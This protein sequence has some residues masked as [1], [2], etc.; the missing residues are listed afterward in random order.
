[1]RQEMNARGLSASASSLTGIRRVISALQSQDVAYRVLEPQSRDADAIADWIE[2]RFP[3]VGMQIDWAR[4]PSSRS[5]KWSDTGE[6]VDSFATLVSDLALN[7]T[8][9]VTW[10]NA[11][12]PSI[13]LAQSDVV[14]I[15][16]SVFGSSFDTWVACPQENWC[17][18][19][20]HEGTLCSGYGCL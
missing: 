3:I 7:H 17:I 5:V 18:E 2:S 15:A 8:V 1:M 14:K 11:L 20:H 4:V 9:R 19:D 6:L 16:V 13:E 10:G 12:R